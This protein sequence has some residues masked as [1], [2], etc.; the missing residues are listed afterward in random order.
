MRVSHRRLVQLFL[1][2]ALVLAP[3]GRIGMAQAMAAMPHRAAMASHCAGLP[4]PDPNPRHKMSVDCMIA[5]AAMAPA[6]APFALQPRLP[7][8]VAPSARPAAILAGIRPEAE[9][10]PPRLA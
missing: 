3:L 8:L 2:A 9:P 1:L 7:A 4:L 6:V 5:C 10:P